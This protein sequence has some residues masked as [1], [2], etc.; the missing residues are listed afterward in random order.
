MAT[1]KPFIS[2][3]VAQ[4]APTLPTL[5]PSQV[6][7]VESVTAQG[8]QSLSDLHGNI[9]NQ[10]ASR[11]SSAL[12]THY[13]M[14]EQSQLAQI[15]FN[16]YVQNPEIID[17]IAAGATN[18]TLLTMKLAEARRIEELPKLEMNFLDTATP[19]IQEGYMYARQ[20]ALKT[21]KP[22]GSDYM[23]LINQY[24]DEQTSEWMKQAPSE[25]AAAEIMSRVQDFKLQALNQGLKIQ[26]DAAKG[27]ALTQV[28]ETGD[29]LIRQAIADPEN[30][31]S[32]LSQS[33][34]LQQTLKEAG[35]TDTEVAKWT[36]EQ[37]NKI[38]VSHMEAQLIRDPNAALSEL[39]YSGITDNMNP[40]SIITLATRVNEAVVRQD[41]AEADKLALQQAYTR[42]LSGGPLNESSSADKKAGDAIY[43]S[44]TDVVRNPNTGAI[45]FTQG[46][47]EVIY[48]G[49]KT[50]KG[51]LPEAAK[52]DLTNALRYGSADSAVGASLIIKRLGQDPD[53]RSQAAAL[54]PKDYQMGVLIANAMAGGETPT[55]AVLDAR[56]QFLS[57]P[58][59][60]TEIRNKQ[61]DVYLK[62]ETVLDDIHGAFSS[63]VA[64]IFGI[65]EFM[66]G[67]GYKSQGQKFFNPENEAEAANEY[68]RL[69]RRA[70][71]ESG[72]EKAAKSWALTQI[73]RT[74]AASTANGKTE[75]MQYAPSVVYGAKETEFNHK[76]WEA[77]A[78][79]M[80]TIPEA[81][82]IV[83]DSVDH[84]GI[85]RAQQ[86]G[87]YPIYMIDKDGYKRP[88]FDK[89]GSQYVYSFT[90]GMS[91]HE[92]EAI[93]EARRKREEI[94]NQ[95]AQRSK[96]RDDVIHHFLMSDKVAGMTAQQKVMLQKQLQTIN[97]GK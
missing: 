2:T 92:V 85:N 53:L 64:P 1:I 51:L 42:V 83:I 60:M 35:Y 69:F 25:T 73:S 12:R 76:F 46:G 32:Y 10:M 61:A 48:Q 96:L 43:G 18:E 27:H 71:L 68:M 63:W 22:D 37:R 90:A 39:A 14:G 75:V 19:K 88:V 94:A 11:A 45:D 84:S 17:A 91:A 40:E 21:M 95:T 62:P 59:S 86:N 33:L 78:E 72:D 82:D 52:N 70:Y 80:A 49:L 79:F 9:A 4:P 50:T 58:G 93:K 66:L 67:E 5:N 38:A 89:N 56:K 47:A 24:F 23:D 31:D 7:Q 41:R 16:N 6:G 34:D 13:S 57:E 15:K 44:I 26:D 97:I 36:A 77:K 8:F 30:F 54:D 55:N 81:T 20:E 3:D 74:W 28:N 29:S 87:T 65:N